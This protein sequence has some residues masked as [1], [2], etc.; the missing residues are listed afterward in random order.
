MIKVID[1]CKK[2][3]DKLVL[4]NI[5]F[6]LDEQLIAILGDT[7][8]G[9][10]VL[11]KII[12]GLILPDCG[13]IE[14]TKNQSIGFVFQHSAL[15]DSLTVLENIRLPLQERTSFRE[16]I[17]DQKVKKIISLLD[18]NEKILRRKVNDL[19]GGERKIVAIARAIIIDPN[20][21]LYDEPTTG[22]D[23]NTHYKIC[24]II[25]NLKKPGILVTHNQQTIKLIGV[26]GTYLLKNGKLESISY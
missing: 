16:E 2:F 23:E 12:A 25:K 11:L 9:K 20:Y 18:I 13:R 17:I 21:V 24:Q 14:I 1:I 19:S 10:S 15:F 8:A 4:D 5:N 7:G 3:N 6:C 26:D 22:L